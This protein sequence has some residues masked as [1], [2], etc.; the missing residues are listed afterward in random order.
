MTI[1]EELTLLDSQLRRLKI[2]Y[3]IFFSNPTKKATHGRRVE[4]ARRV[5]ASP[6][7]DQP[8]LNSTWIKHRPP[9][10]CMG[11]RAEPLGSVEA[12]AS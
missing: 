9:S 10:R 8:Q 11:H 5:A 12:M 4:S 6:S 2:E 1:D 7:C 3:E